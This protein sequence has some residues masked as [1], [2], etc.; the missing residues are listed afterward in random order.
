MWQVPII[1]MT[2]TGGLWYGAA[3]LSNIEAGVKYALLFFVGLADLLLIFVIQRVRS[4]MAAY[5]RKIKEFHPSSFAETQSGEATRWLRERGVVNTFS[6]LLLIAALMSFI[7]LFFI[8]SGSTVPR[9]GSGAEAH[10]P[11]RP[12]AH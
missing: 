1:A 6:V 10:S 8:N 2:V 4:V 12:G 5:L 9:A 7:G 11:A 3:S